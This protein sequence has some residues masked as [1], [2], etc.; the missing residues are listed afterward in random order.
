MLY[1]LISSLL[2]CLEKILWT[3]FVASVAG[4]IVSVRP[5][6]N[7]DVLHDSYV[8]AVCPYIFLYAIY[9]QV[10]TCKCSFCQQHIF[11]TN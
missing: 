7:A 10:N 8:A 4:R 5:C 11:V 1:D 9:N 3:L 2:A 6:L